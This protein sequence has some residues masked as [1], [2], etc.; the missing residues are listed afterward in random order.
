M[1]NRILRT[2]FLLFMMV[3]LA[4]LAL[5]QHEIEE[6]NEDDPDKTLFGKVLQKGRFEFHLRSY[7]MATQNQGSLLDYSTWGTGAGIGYFS[8][9]WR[10]LGAGFSGFFVFRHFENNVTAI[11]P[12]TQSS[13]RYEIL[14]Y[15]LQN[16]NN[17]KD[18][19]RLEEFFLSYE[20]ES[21]SIWAGR[22]HFESPFLNASDN[23]MRPNLFSGFSVGVKPGKL[24]VKAS[25]FS[26]VISRGSLEW[27]S[28]HESFGLYNTGINPLGSEESY[29]HHVDSKGIASLGLDYDSDHAKIESWSYLAEGVFGLSMLQATGQISINSGPQFLWGVQG[30]YESAV[31]NGGND[32]PKKAYILPDEHTNGVGLRGGIKWSNSKLTLNF[33]KISDNGRFLFPREW[34]REDFFVSL[35]RER[36]EGLGGL[37]VKMIKYDQSLVHDKLKIGIGLS[38]V[39]NPDQNDFRLNKYGIPDY[40][41]MSGLVDYRLQG[42]FR[43]LDLQLQ[44]VGKKEAPNQELSPGNVINKVNMMNYSFIVDYRF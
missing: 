27:L 14:L 36:F 10:G 39:D 26:H 24:G 15:D 28:V 18:L 29:K 2:I 21:I 37:D 34:G 12:L 43:G 1:M 5:A 3:G 41:Q 38:Y 23:R 31:G 8:P 6:I 7:F 44:V 25:W 33:L 13:N 22:H 9:R 42:F 20:K 40:Y 11:D 19:D 32:N 4:Q 16:P 35:P 17:H 30:F